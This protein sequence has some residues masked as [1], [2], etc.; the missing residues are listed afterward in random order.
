VRRGRPPP[1]PP[2]LPL[3]LPL[4]RGCPQGLSRRRRPRGYGGVCRR[5]AVA[6]AA[7]CK[8]L[9][10]PHPPCELLNASSR[11]RMCA[12][13]FGE[14]LGMAQTLN[15][16]VRSQER[17]TTRPRPMRWVHFCFLVFISACLILF[18]TVPLGSPNLMPSFSQ[19]PAAV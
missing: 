8:P 6:G 4:P 15:S 3:S 2:P 18:L 10:L 16:G 13:P 14:T 1:P 7:A 12:P 11:H 17:R 19:I 5:H 9:P